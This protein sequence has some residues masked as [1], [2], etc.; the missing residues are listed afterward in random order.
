MTTTASP[1]PSPP[2]GFSRWFRQHAWRHLVGIVALI[3][4]IFPILWAL[5]AA[6]NPTGGLST[7]KPIPTDPSLKNFRTILDNPSQP[8]LKWFVNSLIVSSA[9]A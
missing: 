2:S 3:F 1:T 6:F 9:S 8:F 7:Q 5:S 4:A